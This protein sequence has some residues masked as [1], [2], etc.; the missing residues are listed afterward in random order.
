[1][2]VAADMRKRGI[3]KLILAALGRRASALGVCQLVLETAAHWC[4]VIAFYE[5][6]GFR[7]THYEEGR[8]G[9]EAHFALELV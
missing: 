3:G 1:M 5:A 7:L 9:R 8:F 4:E 6:A 2:S